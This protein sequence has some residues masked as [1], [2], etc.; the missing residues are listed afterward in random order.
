M[1]DCV[2]DTFNA[3]AFLK[4][5]ANP[6]QYRSKLKLLVQSLLPV[7]TGSFK[8]LENA[9][10]ASAEEHLPACNHLRDNWK[11]VFTIIKCLDFALCLN[12]TIGS[13]SSSSSADVLAISSY[14]G[15]QL[16]ELNLKDQV[17]TGEVRKGTG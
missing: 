2:I 10:I 6:D 3:D 7:C 9:E 14:K 11:R 12:L 17:K 16:V 13:D 15:K 8:T 4:M 5:F 1:A